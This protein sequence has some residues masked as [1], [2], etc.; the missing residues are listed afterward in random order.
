[1]TPN[2]KLRLITGS[3]GGIGEQTARGLA[4]IGFRVA[5]VG[6]DPGRAR[7]V[8]HQIRQDTDNQHIDW[9]AADVTNQSDLLRLADEVTRRYDV[10]DILINN[11]GVT[12]PR[13]ELTADGVE[14]TFAGNV[15]APFLL[16][17]LLLPALR[18]AAPARV[19]N[20]TGGV[21]R[22]TDGPDQPAGRAVLRR[23]VALQPDQSRSNG[24]ELHVRSPTDRSGVS[25]N[26]AYPG[27]ALT[28]MN[29]GLPISA[30]P[31]IAR[32]IVPLLRLAGP[33]VYG[34]RAVQ[35]A[36]IQRLPRHESGQPPRHLPRPQM[37]PR[38][39]ARLRPR[40]EEPDGDLG[41]V[42]A[43]E[44]T[45][46]ASKSTELTGTTRQRLDPR[47]TTSPPRSHET[48]FLPLPH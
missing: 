48:A 42:P 16:T 39:V 33:I 10:V 18:R 8:A 2:G 12:R 46:H 7:A 20:I 41:A 14:A 37:P 31:L 40:R 43:I 29:E 32:P 24:H 21:P 6:R 5:L 30:Y 19:I 3:T 25:L 17:H 36:S 27:H 1:M 23:A 9:F 45:P 35:R 26:V 15:V 28:K 13:R 22:R 11:A 4:K 44:Q 38:A 47:P 34:Q